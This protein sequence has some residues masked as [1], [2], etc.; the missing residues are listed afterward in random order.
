MFT[1]VKVSKVLPTRQLLTDPGGNH[2]QYEVK[3]DEAP[4]MC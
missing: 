2:Q 3:I 1:E 4:N